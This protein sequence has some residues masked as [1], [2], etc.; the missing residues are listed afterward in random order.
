LLADS[1]VRIAPRRGSVT[2]VPAQ[3]IAPV[4]KRNE[5]RHLPRFL[6]LGKPSLRPFRWPFFRQGGA[7]WPGGCVKQQMTA[8][9]IYTIAGDGQPGYSGDGGPAT[10]AT[11]AGTL[12][13]AIDRAGNVAVCDGSNPVVRMIAAKS[14]R[15][16]GR[17]V[18][19]GD[20]YTI[21]GGGSQLGDGE[22]ATR[23]A[24]HGPA[25]LA[26]GRPGNLLIADFRDRV[27]SVTG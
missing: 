5:S 14:G 23:A 8:G 3:R 24:L 26:I 7:V 18:T 1:R 21:A 19:A 4:E 17:K 6:N 27:R 13:V 10:A 9:D 11:F 12:A 15:Y 16:F 2:V 20:I 22:P 25:G